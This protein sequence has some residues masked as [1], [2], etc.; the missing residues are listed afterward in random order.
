ML[1]QEIQRMNYHK[2]E[3]VIGVSFLKIKEKSSEVAEADEHRFKGK[4]IKF[5]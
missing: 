3:I 2:L 1:L 5:R 4:S